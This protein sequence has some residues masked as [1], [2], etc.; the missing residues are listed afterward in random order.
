MEGFQNNFDKNVEV[1]ADWR[2]LKE[3]APR[4]ATE[5]IEHIAG[6]ASMEVE[7]KMQA[8]ATLIEAL[9]EEGN[10]NR[11]IANEVAR[12]HAYLEE[13]QRHAGRL[14]QLGVTA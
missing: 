13:E 7:E 3:N 1:L 6:Y 14:V 8:L 10:H 5:R 9:F 12:T 2:S 11:Y 4:G